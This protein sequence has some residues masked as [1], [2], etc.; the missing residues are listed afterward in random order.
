MQKKYQYQLI[1]LNTVASDILSIMGNNKVWT[2]TGDLGAGKTT[3]IKEIVSILGSQDLVSSP[4]YTIANQYIYPQGKIYHI[5]A[6]RIDNEEEAYNAGIEEMIYSGEYTFIEW[7]EKISNLIPNEAV[8]IHISSHAD[9]RIL[10]I[11]TN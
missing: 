11:H 1:E 10:E 8:N 7:P 6:Y 5:D 4:T 3:L 2:F 9:N